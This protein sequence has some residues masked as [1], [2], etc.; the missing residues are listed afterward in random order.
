MPR[1]E[2]I[3][4][5]IQHAE[6]P[7]KPTDIVHHYRPANRRRNVHHFQLINHT[8]LP[9]KVVCDGNIGDHVNRLKFRVDL[10][11]FTS[12]EHMA[13]LLIKTFSTGGYFIVYLDGNAKSFE[14]TFESS[15]LKVFAFALSNPSI[16]GRKIAILDKTND[17][18]S[19]TSDDC[20]K[21]MTSDRCPPINFV[22]GNKHYRVFG[23]IKANSYELGVKPFVFSVKS[24]DHT[25]RFV[26]Q[27][28]NPQ[29]M[30][31]IHHD[32]CVIS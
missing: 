25:W 30:E 8:S 3:Q 28:Y 9:V 15:N 13:G 11:P 16:G 17:L 27:Q 21:Q 18:V 14:E 10:K 1:L 31:V 5:A 7:R 23:E 4:K 19:A 22:H 29:D 26:L 24:R 20:W 6:L 12:Y 32:S 2:E